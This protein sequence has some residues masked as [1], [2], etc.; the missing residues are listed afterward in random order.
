MPVTYVIKFKVVPDRREEFLER[1][2]FVLDAMKHE[3][4]YHAAVLHRDPGDQYSFLLYETWESHEDVLNVQLQRPYRVA[5]HAALPHIL[6]GEREIGIW[7]PIKADWREPAVPLPV[8]DRCA[9]A[10]SDSRSRPSG[11]RPETA[12]PMRALPG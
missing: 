4:N 5:W 8:A 11:H 1:L 2:N 12:S 7:E 9:P 6:E 10:P 3:P